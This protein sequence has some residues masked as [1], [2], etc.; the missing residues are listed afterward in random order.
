MNKDHL[1]LAELLDLIEQLQQRS[2]RCPEPRQ[3]SSVRR[4]KDDLAEY[5]DD[6]AS[7]RLRGRAR[8]RRS[9][10]LFRRI[11]RLHPGTWKT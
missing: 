8:K 4:L 11:I 9:G 6:V 3:S 2:G 10:E 7:G 5:A 1:I